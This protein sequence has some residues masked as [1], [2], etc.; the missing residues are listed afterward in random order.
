MITILT[1]L[2]HYCSELLEKPGFKFKDSEVG[3]NPAEGSYILLESDDMQIYVCNEREEMTWQVRSKHDPKNKNWFSF[4]LIAQLLGH[5]V[6]TGVM[7]AT[8]SDLL[9]KN[10][11]K[12]IKHFRKEEVAETLAKLNKLKSERTQRL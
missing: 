9:S 10:L 11:G 4:D 6:A 1:F 5:K 12:I 7:D 8:N 3:R 2:I